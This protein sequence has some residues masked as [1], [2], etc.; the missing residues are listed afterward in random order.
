MSSNSAPQRTSGLSVG[1]LILGILSV[2]AFWFTSIAAIIC[3]HIA[4]SKIKKS[5]DHLRG[6]TAAIWG[7]I[8]GYFF[9]ILAPV[10]LVTAVVNPSLIFATI[11]GKSIREY[12]TERFAKRAGLVN[13]A[14]ATAVDYRSVFSMDGMEFLC[15]EMPTTDLP[16]FL[17]QSGLDNDLSNTTYSASFERMFG[18]FLP[19]VPTKFREGQKSLPNEDWLNVLVDLDSQETAMIFMCLFGT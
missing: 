7:L 10:L 4:L 5:N 17:T 2:V 11:E 3:G 12:N 14:S 13:P 1:S 19:S 6:K 9:T 15:L 18:N 16:E 8:L